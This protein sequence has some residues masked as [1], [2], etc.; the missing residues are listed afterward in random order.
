MLPDV[1]WTYLFEVSGSRPAGAFT[2]TPRYDGVLVQVGSS[3]RWGAPLR[4]ALGQLLARRWVGDAI[5]FTPSGHPAELGWFNDGVA[6]YLATRVLAR[7]EVLTSKEWAEAI[8]QELSVVAT[9]PYATEGNAAVAAR[10]EGDPAA[11]ALLM[12]RGALF[13]ARESAIIRERTKGAGS[14]EAVLM[15]L[16]ARARSA[17]S[18]RF[19]ALPLSAWFEETAKEDAGAAAA[20]DAFVVRGERVTLPPGALG[21]CFRSGIGEY[22]AFDAGFDVEATRRAEDRKVVG[23]RSDGPAARAGLGAEDVVEGIEAE[24]GDASVPVRVVVLREGK[25]G[26]VSSARTGARGG[27]QTWGRVAGGGRG[28]VR[29][30][31]VTAGPPH[32]WASA[33][34]SAATPSPQRMRASPFSNGRVATSGSVLLTPAGLDPGALGATPRRWRRG[35]RDARHRRHHRRGRT[36]RRDDR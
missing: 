1:P 34:A 4:L 23:L 32:G 5:R 13:A 25:R 10:A 15:A 30:A 35:R 9:S 6:R 22:V 7:V 20:F 19:D 24:E 26:V 21:P 14:L 33:T 36:R 28:A 18:G 16:L 12:A 11:R 17:T 2:V 31:A 27:G 29:A 8:A 3:Q